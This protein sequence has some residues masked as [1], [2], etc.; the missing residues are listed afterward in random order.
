MSD[1]AR[2]MLDCAFC[3]QTFYDGSGRDPKKAPGRHLCGQKLKWVYITDAELEQRIATAYFCSPCINRFYIAYRSSKKTWG[4]KTDA[5]LA[6]C[7][8]SCHHER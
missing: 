4:E 7:K 5:H 1:E 2:L 3:N 8:C 6:H